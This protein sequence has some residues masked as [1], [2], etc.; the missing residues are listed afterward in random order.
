MIVELSATGTVVVQTT[1]ATD[2]SID[3]VGWFTMP[4]RHFTY[5]YGPSGLRTA[6]NLEAAGGWRHEYTWSASGGIPLLLAEHRGLQVSY[7]I[8]GPGG[9]PIYQVTRD[10]QVIYYHQDHLGST[11]Y[12]TDAYGNPRGTINYTAHGRITTNTQSPWAEQAMLGYTGQ[13]H[14]TETGYIYL[15][16]RHYDPANAQF[17]TLDPLVAITQEPYG[18]TQGNPAN[19]T[20]PTGMVAGAII[21]AGAAIIVLRNRQGIQYLASKVGE[22]A[23]EHFG[24]PE[25]CRD[26]GLVNAVR[27]FVGSALVTHILVEEYGRTLGLAASILAQQ[28]HEIEG[29]CSGLGLWGNGGKW[30]STDATADQHNNALGTSLGLA[31]HNMKSTEFVGFVKTAV[32]WFLLGR[33]LNLGGGFD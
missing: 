27:H 6:K 32:K 15:R 14:D 4:T 17:T 9:T 10:N 24:P 1:T 19:R 29:L 31:M 12:T 22:Y 8:Y 11:R 16:A 7:V 3:V 25:R 13:Y 30:S 33:A 21:P 28:A 20:D 5:D 26:T 18:Y 23:C 2:L